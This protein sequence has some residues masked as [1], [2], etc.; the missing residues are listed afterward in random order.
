MYNSIQKSA[1]KVA[2]EREKAKK[3]LIVKRKPHGEFIMGL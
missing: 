1:A 2:V 3:R